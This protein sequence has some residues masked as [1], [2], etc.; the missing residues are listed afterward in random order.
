[1]LDNVGE[2]LDATK[3]I[4]IATD[5]TDDAFF[6]DITS[7]IRKTHRV[8]QFHD[9]FG[10]TGLFKDKVQ[11]PRRLSGHVEQVICA[12]GRTFVGTTHS[13]FSSY[14]VRLR[15][16]MNAPDQ[17]RFIHSHKGVVPTPEHFDM[18]LDM[19]TELPWL[20]DADLGR[21]LIEA[22]VTECIRRI[23]GVCMVCG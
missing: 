17:R 7:D 13:T 10:P 16:Y 8:W 6:A 20:W 1:M 5:E 12:A 9:F 23:A 4:Y 18:L 15:G 11:I 2:A 14:I 21:G 22:G 3:Q 19:Y